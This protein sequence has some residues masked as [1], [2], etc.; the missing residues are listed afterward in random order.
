MPKEPEL[1]FIMEWVGPGKGP[2]AYQMWA[3]RGERKGC[4]KRVL[5]TKRHC[6]D[7]V[8]PDMEDTL[9]EIIKRLERGDA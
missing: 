9:G 8:L 6:A 5:K 3:C 2:D 7:C 1:E 4:K